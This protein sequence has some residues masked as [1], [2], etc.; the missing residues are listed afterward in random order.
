MRRHPKST[1]PFL[2]L[3]QGSQQVHRAL[4]PLYFTV[5]NL[6]PGARE[7]PMWGRG[8]SRASPRAPA[9]LPP[10]GPWLG[11][12]RQRL[13]FEASETEPLVSGPSP[14]GGTRL[15]SCLHLLP[16]SRAGPDLGLLSASLPEI[17]SNKC[18]KQTGQLQTITLGFLSN[19]HKMGCGWD[20]LASSLC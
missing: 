10:R 9:S 11:C 2:E 16:T 8:V 12:L 17:C 13:F 15:G 6:R 20:C 3:T 7:L 1:L 19:M 4:V 5:G 18:C 14:P